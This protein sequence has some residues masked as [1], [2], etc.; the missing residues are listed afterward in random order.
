MP[1]ASGSHLGPYAILGPLGAGGMGEVYRALDE[2]LQRQVA[3]KVLQ[4]ELA[5]DPQALQRFLR[6]ARAV[7]ALSHPNIL[8]IHDVGMEDGTAFAVMELLEGETLR[9][10]LRAGPLAPARILTLAVPVLR[11]LAAAHQRG[12]VHRD[13]KP[14]NVFL[15]GDGQVKILDFGLAKDVAPGDLSEATTRAP[16]LS[17]AGAVF[18]TVGYMAPEQLRGEPANP[19]SDLF[20]FGCLLYEMLAGRFAFRRSSAAETIAATLAEEPAP[21]APHPLASLVRR[22]L[23]KRPSERPPSAQA[24]LAELEQG[25]TPATVRRPA[26]RRRPKLDSVAVLPFVQH[27]ADA[28]ATEYLCD[29]LAESI[30]SG[31]AQL[32]KLRVLARSTVMRFR[33]RDL[34]PLAVGR[35]LGV[36][37]VFTGRLSER[38]GR[39]AIDCE[40]VAVDDGERLWGARYDRAEADVLAVEQEIARTLADH[41]RQRLTRQ[42]R[43]RLAKPQTADADAY[44]AYLRGRQ[45]WSRWNPESMRSSI[46]HYQDAIAIDPLY[47]RA[48]AGVGDSWAA[49]GQTKAVAP[50]DAFPQA[51]AATLRAL[52]LDPEL[53]EAHASLGFLR[54]FFEWDWAGAES[55][56]RRALE[57]SPGY[58]TAHRWYGHL[59]SGLARHEPAIAQLELALELDPLSP[60]LHTAAGDTFF[61]ARRYDDA[62]A[63]YR[64]ALAMDPQLLAGHSDIARAL[65]YTGRIDEAVAEYEQAIGLAAG[66]ADPSAGLANVYAVAGRRAEALAVVGTLERGRAERYV[67][68][69]AL[70]SIYARLGEIGPAL[71]WLERGHEERDTTLVWLKVHPRFDPLREEARFQ[72]LLERM[73]LA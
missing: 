68:P 59:L 48:W 71:D 16:A 46:V 23:A 49:L 20:A 15:T 25:M 63:C 55:A 2:R 10:H 65:E 3:I 38:A 31:L 5:G 29:G 28:D 64:R 58:A 42:Q 41:L 18:G 35:E 39:L 4:P 51:K 66:L 8:A 52:E 62:I 1:L 50:Q 70:A 6:E 30:V 54:R 67:S 60:I 19:R 73:R 44:R 11:G 9:D 33:G 21:L 14:E 34:D 53:A 27:G 47:A 45:S 26:S 17:T 12:I 61:Y 56:L 7:A 22:C 72:A 40:L 37:A 43:R 36:S 24:L 69:W 32:P 57:L 13:L